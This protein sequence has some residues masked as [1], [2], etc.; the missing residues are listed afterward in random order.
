MRIV[1]IVESKHW[2]NTKT[3][4]TA[5]IYGAVPWSSDSERQDWELVTRGFTWRLDNGTTGLGRTPVKT[6]QEAL[7]IMHTFNNRG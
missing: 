2:V 7:D 3:G 5:S 1:E 6:M 4:H